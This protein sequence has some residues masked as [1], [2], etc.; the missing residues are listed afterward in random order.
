M[1]ASSKK[2]GNLSSTFKKADSAYS[3]SD[4]QFKDKNKQQTLLSECKQFYKTRR[5]A[6]SGLHLSICV[7]KRPTQLVRKSL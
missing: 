4:R 6:Y 1:A 7:I 2:M 5:Y 3:I